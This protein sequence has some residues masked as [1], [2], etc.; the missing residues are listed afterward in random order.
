MVE[1]YWERQ[2]RIANME[3]RISGYPKQS[4]IPPKPWLAEEISLDGGRF[5]SEGLGAPS[6]EDYERWFIDKI[7]RSAVFVNK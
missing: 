5:I 7:T 4:E 3:E 6:A 2:E 1:S